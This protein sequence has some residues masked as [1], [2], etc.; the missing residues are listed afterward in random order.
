[1]PAQAG[2][3][4]AEGRINGSL[5]LS[6]ALGDMDYKQHAALGPDAQMVRNL[7]PE[8]S[9]KTLSPQYSAVRHGLQ[10]ARRARAGRAD[11]APCLAVCIRHLS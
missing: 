7:K 10:A 1:M 8:P 5:N 2:G 4:V 11:G 3:F 6:R 9:Q